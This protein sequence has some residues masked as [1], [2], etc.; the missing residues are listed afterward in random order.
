MNI[1]LA[2]IAFALVAAAPAVA[3]NSQTRQVQV[4]PETQANDRWCRFHGL[5]HGD[6]LICS[7]YTYE[8]CMASRN[9]GDA[10]CFLN[11]RYARR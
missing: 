5:D 4:Q 3:Q 6:V 11:P 9:P 1:R 8:Q 7:A 10:T 2:L